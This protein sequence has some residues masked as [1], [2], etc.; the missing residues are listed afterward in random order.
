[1][2]AFWGYPLRR[3]FI[4]PER[5]NTQHGGVD[6]KIQTAISALNA[7]DRSRNCQRSAVMDDF[8]GDMTIKPQTRREQRGPWTAPRKRKRR[9]TTWSAFFSD[10][11][12]TLDEE[13]FLF[14]MERYTRLVNRFPTLPEVL[15]VAK[16][17]GY[18]RRRHG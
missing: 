14:A 12:Y 9:N 13:E 8:R 11:E 2:P 10:W 17:L 5:L 3:I 4:L 1:M 18:R 16:S 15:A 6:G 7:N